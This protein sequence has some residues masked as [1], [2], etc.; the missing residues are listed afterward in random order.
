MNL[1]Y[2]FDTKV[3]NIIELLL[4]TDIMLLNVA[5]VWLAVVNCDLLNSVTVL[6]WFIQVFY[7]FQRSIVAFY[8]L[9]W[10][11]WSIKV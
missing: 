8:N 9:Q 5:S 1:K 11:L 3:L 10:L 4:K 7:G 2:N 6:S